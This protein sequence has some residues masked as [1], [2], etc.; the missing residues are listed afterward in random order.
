[1]AFSPSVAKDGHRM[2]TRA[3]ARLAQSERQKP[4]K[5]SRVEQF[6]FDTLMM[7]CKEGNIRILQE[8]LRHDNA[9]VNQKDE[10]GLTPLCVTCKFGHVDAVTMLLRFHSID[11]NKTSEE[12]T[13]LWIACAYG[14]VDVVRV[15]LQ[16]EKIDLMQ[17][18]KDGETPYML[19]VDLVMCTSLEHCCGKGESKPIVSTKLIKGDAPCSAL[20]RQLF[21]L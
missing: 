11:I 13:P 5:K 17:A 18:D 8:Q 14:Y 1:M 6:S 3:R 10:L 15:L 4:S 21:M 9:N 7:A 19:L 16:K 20:L 2:Q 12:G